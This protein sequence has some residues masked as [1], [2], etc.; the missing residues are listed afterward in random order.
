[1]DAAITELLAGIYEPD[2]R[3]ER[4]LESLSGSLKTWDH[5]Q[6]QGIPAPRCT[7]ERIMRVYGGRGVAGPARFAP[8]PQ[9]RRSAGHRTWS[10]AISRLGGR[11]SCS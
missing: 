5:L 8:P 4:P 6:R 11:M 7:V 9:T 3:G 2:Q 10:G 1:V